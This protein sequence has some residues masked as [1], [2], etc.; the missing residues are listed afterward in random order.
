VGLDALRP[1]PNCPP[2]QGKH[3]NRP[4]RRERAQ[5]LLADSADAIHQAM[6]GRD[7]IRLLCRKAD[8]R[9][10]L[11]LSWP[12]LSSLRISAT[13]L[14]PYVERANSADGKTKGL[15]LCVGPTGAESQRGERDLIPTKRSEG[16]GGNHIGVPGVYLNDT[17]TGR[18]IRNARVRL[19]CM[20]MQIDRTHYRTTE[21][22]AR[23]QR[24][25][26]YFDTL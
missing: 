13:G 19:I 25:A 24:S 12:W 17:T 3:P 1:G 18:R 14:V 8:G 2:G 26:T 10:D 22:T 23:R 15:R 16:I 9:E 20:P 7:S 5:S 11:R 4:D 6:E 21:E